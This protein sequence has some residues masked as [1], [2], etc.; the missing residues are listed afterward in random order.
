MRISSRELILR[1]AKCGV[2]ADILRYSRNQKYIKCH[3][4]RDDKTGT[5]YFEY[6]IDEVER[7]IR[8]YLRPKDGAR[9]RWRK[10]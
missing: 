8:E 2:S 1:Y 5:M 10:K 7:W 4:E 6:D 9:G 3:I